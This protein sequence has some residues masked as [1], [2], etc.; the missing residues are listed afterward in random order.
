MPILFCLPVRMTRPAPGINWWRTPGP[1]GILIVGG[2]LQV[3]GASS[4]PARSDPAISMSGSRPPEVARPA[5]GDQGRLGREQLLKQADAR[6]GDAQGY[7]GQPHD[8]EHDDHGPEPPGTGRPG[9][10]LKAARASAP[11]AGPRRCPGRNGSAARPPRRPARPD[12][13]GWPPPP[14]PPRPRWPGNA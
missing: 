1:F 14:R 11:R 2:R 12:A 5:G 13:G 10:V 9:R 4:A 3:R 7:Q 8:R 6:A